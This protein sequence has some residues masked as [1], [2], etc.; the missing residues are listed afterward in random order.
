MNIKKSDKSVMNENS[1]STEMKTLIERSKSPFESTDEYINKI[2]KLH[3]NYNSQKGKEFIESIFQEKFLKYSSDYLIKYDS[4]GK[5]EKIKN[6]TKEQIKLS[7]HEML[8]E[9]DD[10]ILT[11]LLLIDESF[12]LLFQTE[13]YDALSKN[14]ETEDS[15]QEIQNEKLES[16]ISA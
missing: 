8:N 15:F 9:N 3:N 7:V 1:I 13:F 14:G 5:N 10:N 2:I 4:K 11:L 16:S 12:S 6:K